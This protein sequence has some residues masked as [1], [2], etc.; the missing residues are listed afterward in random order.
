[1]AV[2]P[3]EYLHLQAPEVALIK[4]DK[5]FQSSCDDDYIIFSPHS[6]GF[7]PRPWKKS[8]VTFGHLV[9]SFFRRKG[10]SRTRFLHKLHNALCLSEIDPSFFSI[11][12]VQ[13]LTDHII[14]V[15]K[16]TFARLLGIRTPDGSLFHRQG[17]FP[18]HGF[19]EVSPSQAR[20][21]LSPSV[22]Q[23]VDYDNIRLFVHGSGEFFRGCD[24]RIETTCHWLNRRKQEPKSER[25]A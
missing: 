23:T 10:S 9:D 15:D 6:L 20:A 17:N 25:D 24:A 8:F 3:S 16:A 5:D 21:T 18:S 19:V 22:L 4:S 2:S 12:G 14:C 1:M 11:V 7:L 13:W